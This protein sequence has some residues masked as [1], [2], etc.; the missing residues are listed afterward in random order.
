MTPSGDL[1]QRLQTG[2]GWF[3][4]QS[5][6][7]RISLIV[8]ASIIGPIGMIAL[9]SFISDNF[10]T[11]LVLL[12]VMAFLS[13]GTGLVLY[14][15]MKR[16]NEAP[17]VPENSIACPSCGDVNGQ[18]AEFC[19]NC[20][21]PFKDQKMLAEFLAYRERNPVKDDAWSP[22][23]PQAPS[24]PTAAPPPPRRQVVLAT[25][26]S[27]TW[28]AVMTLLLYLFLCWPIGALANL[29]WLSEADKI[30]RRTGVSPSGRGCLRL[31]GWAFIL[32]PFMLAVI[33]G[34]FLYQSRGTMVPQ[35][36][37]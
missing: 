20:A 37:P 29:M 26:R 16:Q 30:Y 7:T 35:A 10:V 9:Y 25:D 2:L 34:I 4:R 21:R 32:V 33:I 15:R 1:L 11:I 5:E 22:A 23:P 13:V 36:P 31:L 19:R 8:A 17:P 12:A 18:E 27:F 24:A 3:N 14:F 6:N 28:P